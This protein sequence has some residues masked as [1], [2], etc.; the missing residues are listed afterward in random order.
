MK[1][2]YDKASGQARLGFEADI[3]GEKIPITFSG[4]ITLLEPEEKL[5]D[6]TSRADKALYVAKKGI[7]G[8]DGKKIPGRNQIL[9]YVA[10]EDISL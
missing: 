7:E 8:E 5:E 10:S 2:F 1:K 9:P 6:A 4:G 3:E